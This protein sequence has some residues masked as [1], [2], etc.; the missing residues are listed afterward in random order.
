MAVLYAGA[1]KPDRVDEVD[2]ASIIQLRLHGASV[3]VIDDVLV[4]T[5]A[6]FASLMS[7]EM[8]QVGIIINNRPEL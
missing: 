7:W 2:G 1:T 3:D 8:V 4:T 5:F 6:P